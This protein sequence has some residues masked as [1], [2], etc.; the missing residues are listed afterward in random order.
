[1]DGFHTEADG[2]ELL[3][4]KYTSSVWRALSWKDRSLLLETMERSR[5]GIDEGQRGHCGV[6]FLPELDVDQLRAVSRR[7]ES[8]VKALVEMN[9]TQ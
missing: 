5:C 8:I 4:S 9:V 2:K 1:M 6:L 7:H 3:L